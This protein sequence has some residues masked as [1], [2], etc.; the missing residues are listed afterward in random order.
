M[1]C[2]IRNFGYL[3]FSFIPSAGAPHSHSLL[4]LLT[5]VPPAPF[6]GST[7]YFIND[8]VSMFIPTTDKVRLSFILD[9]LQIYLQ[10]VCIPVVLSRKSLQYRLVLM[11][12]A[13]EEQEAE[14]LSELRGREGNP[15][16]NLEL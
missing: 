6:T 4:V 5:A 12:N 1:I 10:G 14:N 16:T 9:A 15:C 8:P 13:K 3:H 11:Y 2:L 7:G